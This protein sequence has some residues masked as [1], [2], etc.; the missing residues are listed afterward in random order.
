MMNPNLDT[1]YFFCMGCEIGLGVNTILSSS[2]I[3]S[4]KKITIK[5]IDKEGDKV[6]FLIIIRWI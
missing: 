3:N 5:K 1:S 2:N 6:Y 4:N